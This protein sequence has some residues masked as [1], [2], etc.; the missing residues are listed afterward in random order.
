MIRHFIR[1]ELLPR[2]VYLPWFLAWIWLLFITPIHFFRRWNQKST[3][4]SSC[5]C[6]EA[7]ERGWQSIEFKELYQSACEYLDTDHVVKFAVKHDQDYVAQVKSVLRSHPISHYVYDPRTG[8]QQW[9][10]GLWQSLQVATL[11]QQHHVIPIVLLT[12]LSV[13][14]WRAQSAVVSA[15]KGVVV[16]FMSA[17]IMHPIFPHKRLLGPSL[18]PFS[19]RTKT[20]LD[21]M[22]NIRQLNDKP[23]AIFTGSL[24]EPRTSILR[25]VESGVKARGGNFDVLGRI[26]GT[27]RVADEEYWSRLINADIVFTT[28]VQMQ[29]EGTDWIRIPHFLYRYLEVLVSGSLLVAQDVPSVRRYLTPGLHYVPYE[30]PADAVE[31]IL[32]YLDDPP[33][34]AKIARQGKERVDSLINARSFWM[35]IDSF[36]GKEAIA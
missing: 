26:I 5:I 13:R 25:Q 11:L 29:Q 30:T 3:G 12:D 1:E 9:W 22:I 2:L 7:G 19:V 17:K 28:S 10:S 33:A 4:S 18:M 15:R 6:I 34:R 8:I 35:L 21:S 32:R 14:I 36:L 20:A 27:S 24:Y 16:S 31:L 23:R